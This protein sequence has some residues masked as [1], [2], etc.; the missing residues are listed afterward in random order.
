MC[1]KETALCPATMLTVP[2]GVTMNQINEKQLA[3]KMFFAAKDLKDLYKKSVRKITRNVKEGDITRA[4]A[5]IEKQ[6]AKEKYGQ[7]KQLWEERY[8]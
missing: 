1:H 6:R 2:V 7:Y 3:D 5:R 8:K 4:E